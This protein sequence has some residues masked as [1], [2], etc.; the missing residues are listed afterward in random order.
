MLG[1]ALNSEALGSYHAP[2]GPAVSSSFITFSFN[3]YRFLFTQEYGYLLKVQIGTNLAFKAQTLS[4]SPYHKERLH[5]TQWGAEGASCIL[6]YTSS[7]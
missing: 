5:I 2:P 3:E 7:F 6:K 1:L 4:E